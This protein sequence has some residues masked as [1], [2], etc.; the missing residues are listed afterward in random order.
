MIGS[1]CRKGLKGLIKLVGHDNGRLAC[2]NGDPLLAYGFDCI[3]DTIGDDCVE[4]VYHVL[5]IWQ[6]VVVGIRKVV[7][8]LCPLPSVLAAIPD[9]FRRKL[10]P[11]GQLLH[12]PDF[13]L[14]E[15]LLLTT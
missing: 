11:I 13:R 15:K 4:D 12:P 1:N 5:F 6:A 9:A 7:L 8:D 2:F 10:L 14:L 3:D